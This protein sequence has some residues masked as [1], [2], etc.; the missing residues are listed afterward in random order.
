MELSEPQ[1]WQYSSAEV[2][3]PITYEDEI[4]GFCKP[5]FAARIVKALNDDEK[6][7]RALWLACQDLVRRSNGRSGPVDDLMQEYLAKSDRSKTGVAAIAALL[8]YRQQELD[9][10]DR[11]FL[12]FCDSYRLSKEKV[13]AIYEGEDIDNSLLIP[14]SRVLGRS[15]DDLLE[16]LEGTAHIQ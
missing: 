8:R 6:L 11:E 14:L 2:Y 3:F 15:V 7:H 5:D 10:S 4:V 1:P 9:V 13:Q 12:R 16:L